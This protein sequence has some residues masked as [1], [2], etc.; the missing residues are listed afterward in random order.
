M[1]EIIALKATPG[2][3]PIFPG[4][5]T[6]VWRYQAQ[7]LK[8]EGSSLVH[9]QRSYLGPIIRVPKGQK[10]RIRFTNDISDETIV[11]RHSLHVPASMDGH[12]R[13]VV[14]RGETYIYEFEIR[15]RAGTYWYHPHPHGRTGLQ[16]YGGMA[17]FF[18]VSD[19][20][21]QAAGLPDGK[22]DTPLVIQDRTFG[23][24]NQLVYLSG[25]PMERMN[26]FL[27]DWIL[28]RYK[29]L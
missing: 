18:L 8:G 7:V 5:T 3:V 15:N 6:G 21:E 22:Y 20:E 19:D 14:P 27:G 17:G 24:S 1:A 12:P 2:Q 25:H 29:Y 4:N 28:A 11:H 13:L 16:V 26:G 10:V 9:L 23:N